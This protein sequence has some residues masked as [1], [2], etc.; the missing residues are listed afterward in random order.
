MPARRALP[1]HAGDAEVEHLGHRPRPDAME[2]DVGRLH[3]AMD[4]PRPVG[5][6]Q[7]FAHGSG[8]RH[9]VLDAEG[10][11]RRQLGVERVALQQLHHEIGDAARDREVED[12]HRVRMAH[13]AGGD[14]LPPEAVEGVTGLERPRAQDLHRHRAVQLE[15]AGAIHGPVVAG[16]DARLEAV[17]AAEHGA[18]ADFGQ[19]DRRR[20]RGL[21][22]RA[23][24]RLDA[25]HRHRE[26]DGLGH[27]VVGA[28]AERLHDVRAV[29][30]RGDHDD[31]RSACSAS[32]STPAARPCPASRGRGARG[33]RRPRGAPPARRGRRRPASWPSL[34]ARGAG[35]SSRGCHRRRRR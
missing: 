33:P 12:R 32:P 6:G 17:A 22:P 4:D 8:D 9:R 18:D 11:A 19:R 14:A 24:R 20:G 2:E 31:R 21:A 10:R 15:M 5:L 26:V 25:G 35:S 7:R 16:A 13:A 29:G 34:R 30:G 27:V 23:Q 3:V 28:L 1:E